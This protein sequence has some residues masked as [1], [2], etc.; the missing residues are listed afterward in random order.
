MAKVFCVA[1]LGASGLLLGLAAYSWHE[2]W[3]GGVVLWL[4]AALIAYG[5]AVNWYKVAAGPA[6]RVVARRETAGAAAE[7]N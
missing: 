5:E 4:S 7:D 2:D 1:T 3:Y 6:G